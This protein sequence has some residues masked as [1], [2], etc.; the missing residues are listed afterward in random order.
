MPETDIDSQ[1]GYFDNVRQDLIEMI[2][3]Q[4]LSILEIGSADGATLATL[5]Q[6]GIAH[7]TTG[8]ELRRLPGQDKYRNYIDKLIID[9]IEHIASSLPQRSYDVII[10]ADVLE[11]LIN[12]WGILSHLRRCLKPNGK[13]IA[14]IP[15]ICYVGAIKKIVIN[16]DFRYEKQGVFDQTHL[17]F[18]CKRNIIEL[19]TQTGFE[20]VSLTS[21]VDGRNRTKWLVNRLTLGIFYEYLVKQF[22]VEAVLSRN[23]HV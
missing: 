9:D 18:F 3:G 23:L 7:H 13:I 10:C 19:F 1:K 4:G 20:I 17:R 8:I 5:K 11:H 15:N 2:S 16:R 6:Q 12:P 22:F 14:S 21:T